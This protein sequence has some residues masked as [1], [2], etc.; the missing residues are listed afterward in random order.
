MG[1]YNG[2]NEEMNEKLLKAGEWHH[3]L[4]TQ[5]ELCYITVYV[6]GEE[7]YRAYNQARRIMCT[8]PSFSWEVGVGR[9]SA[10]GHSGDSKNPD[11][12]AGMI[13]RLFAGSIAEI[14]MFKGA[15]DVS[16]SL[17]ATEFNAS[18]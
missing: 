18:K 3:V 5:D 6:D 4:V 9:K 12:P 10:A 14:R 17:Y 15:I 1:D 2:I 11:D 16:D 8:D 13:R 7:L